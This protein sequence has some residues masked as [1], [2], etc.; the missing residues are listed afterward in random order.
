M[1]IED[2]FIY[3]NAVEKKYADAMHRLEM[4]LQLVDMF[5]NKHG[6]T[7]GFE[8]EIKAMLELYEYPSNTHAGFPLSV[9][10]QLP[11]PVISQLNQEL[12]I[13]AK[14]YYDLLDEGKDPGEALTFIS[15]V[16]S[17]DASMLCDPKVRHSIERVTGMLNL[18]RL[19]R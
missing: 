19:V 4:A 2:W 6:D 9:L 12:N 1:Q 11:V 17:G 7:E 10:D 15:M 16:I 13:A 18:K 8:E 5:V 3:V 14:K